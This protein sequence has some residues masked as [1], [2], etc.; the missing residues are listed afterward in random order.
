M[1][2]VDSQIHLWQ[3]GTMSG[4]HRQIPTYCGIPTRSASWGTSIWSARIASRSWRAGASGRACSA[5]AS[6]STSRISRR[7]GPTARST[8]SGRRPRRRACRSGSWPAATWRRWRRSPRATRGS[9]CTSTTSDASAA[10]RPAATTRRSPIPAVPLHEHPRLSA[11]GLRGVR[12]RPLLLG[13]RHHAHAVLVA[14][15]RDDVHRGAAVAE[16]PRP[17]ARD[18][19]GHRRL[20]GLEAPGCPVRRPA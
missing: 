11:P 18:G 14:P 16:G 5:S 13:H 20:A 8:G 19:R 7:G 15:V 6:P 10:A 17:R 3:N 12:A 2:I 4:H 1:L 9:S